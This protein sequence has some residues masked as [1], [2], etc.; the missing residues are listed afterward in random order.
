VILRIARKQVVPRE[1]HGLEHLAAAVDAL[2]FDE[3]GDPALL[4]H[5]PVILVEIFVRAARGREDLK[6]ETANVEKTRPNR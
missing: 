1:R 3:H 4:G 2:G 5:D 6:E